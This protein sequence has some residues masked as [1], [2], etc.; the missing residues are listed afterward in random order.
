MSAIKKLAGETALYGLGTI[1]PRLFNFLLLPLHTAVFAPEAYGVIT[2]LYAFVAFI[3]VVYMWGMETAYFRFATK[4]GAD[5]VQVFNLAQTVV[6]T[7]SFSFSL[8]FIAFKFPIASYLNINGNEHYVTWLAGIMAI[9]ALVAIPFARLR[10]EK[11]PKTF[12]AAKITSVALLLILNYYFLKVNYQ[13]EIGIGYVFLANLMGNAVLIIFFVKQLAAW[14]P[15]YHREITPAMFRYAYPVM[16]TGVAGMVNEMFSRITLEWWLPEN[17]YPGKPSA[18][19]LGVF[20]ACYKYAVFMS[21]AVQAFRFAAEPFFFSHAQDKHSPNLFARVNHYF[22]IA[23]CLILLGVSLNLDLLKYIL[24]DPQYWEGLVIV[25]ILLTA[26]LFLG[27]Y[28]N[29]SVWFKLTDKTYFGTLFSVGGAVIT[30]AANYMLIPVLGYVGSSIAALLCYVSMT[31]ACYKTGQAYFPIPY[32]IGK[33]LLYIVVALVL[34]YIGTW[35][36]IERYWLAMLFHNSLVLGYGGLVYFLERSA[37][38]PTV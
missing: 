15:A 5:A 27:I 10:L 13:E 37:A 33:S 2:Y 38:Q 28:Y 20:G 18:Y 24:G 32:R 6:V 3:N 17:F 35:I 25:P 4:P 19:A 31:I 14:R 30:V 36:P 12:A 34:I 26:Y 8:L 22:V 23:G 16:L 1:V 29:L 11:K 9:D 7:I 21:L